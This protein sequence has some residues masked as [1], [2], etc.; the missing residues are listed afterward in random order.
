MLMFSRYTW[1]VGAMIA[2]ALLL[3]VMSQVG[4][5]SPF[6]GLFLQVAAPFENALTAVF[7]PVASSL[8]NLGNLN[9]L[10]NENAKLR[11]ENEDLHNQ[12]TTL[13]QDA[14]EVNDLREALKITQSAGADTRVAASVV[15]RDSSPFTETVSIDKGGN[16]GIRVG[17]VVLSAQGSLVGTVTTVNPN[18]AFVRLITD[19]KSKV[20]AQILESKALGIVQGNPGRALTFDL[21]QADAK[22][23]DTV[24]TSGLG[25]NYPPDY[26]IGRVS[27]VSGTP[28]DLFRKV[29]VEP[30]VRVSTVSTVLVLTSFMPQR[31]GVGSP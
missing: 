29:K 1:W 17:M 25:G 9:D 6:Q 16:A 15:G 11:V 19:T 28:Q 24:I 14:Q 7:E 20:N 2:L 22:V 10:Q 5:M 12:I 13:Q 21:S 18:T 8:A 26:A 4:L 31:I 23:G 3:A 30:L 27:D